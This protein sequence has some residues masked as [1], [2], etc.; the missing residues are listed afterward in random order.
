MSQKL[1]FTFRLLRRLDIDYYNVVFK[2]YITIA[3]VF[4][5]PTLSLIAFVI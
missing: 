4:M 5:L 3:G 2:R 1:I